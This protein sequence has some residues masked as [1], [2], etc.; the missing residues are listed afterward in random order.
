MRSELF[1]LLVASL[2]TVTQACSCFGPQTFCETL[3]PQPP[4]FPEP[5]WWTPDEIVL[6][7]KLA[8]VEYGADVKVVRCFTGGLQVDSVIRVWGDCGLL[9]RHYVNGPA[10]GDTLLW[11]I[12]HTDLMGNGPCGT[13]LEQMQ[14]WA[15]SVC[16]VYWLNYENG[17]V[18]G[19]LTTD[20]VNQSMD[21]EEFAD[22]INGCLPTSMPEE[23]SAMAL[24]VSYVDGTPF[25]S[26]PVLSGDA[27]LQ[28]TDMKGRVVL[29][30]RWDGM[31]LP[32]ESVAPG[33]YI[34]QVS[35]RGRSWAQRMV[36]AD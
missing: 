17:I 11:A 9:C 10:N 26:C 8:D 3:D 36:V 13:S 22:L 23:E 21:V 14:D 35:T 27:E 30:R 24:R 2:S 6:V 16:G 28:V 31:P 5:E 20:N 25:V 29:R 4:Q 19:P 12:D 18:S 1:C 32:F 33:L 7:V 34:A 15:L